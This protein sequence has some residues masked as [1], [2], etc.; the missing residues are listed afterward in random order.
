[1][2]VSGDSATNVLSEGHLLCCESWTSLGRYEFR[3]RHAQSFRSWGGAQLP[4]VFT[5]G[6]ECFSTIVIIVIF[7][8]VSKCREPHRRGGCSGIIHRTRHV[9][10]VRVKKERPMFLENKTNKYMLNAFQDNGRRDDTTDLNYRQTLV[11]H[12][13]TH[14]SPFPYALVPDF[15]LSTGSDQQCRLPR[16]GST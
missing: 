15:L 3:L 5:G 8:R 6:S 2:H 10:G 1:M 14:V 12:C 7:A 11:D 4:K 16:P 13:Q 9:R